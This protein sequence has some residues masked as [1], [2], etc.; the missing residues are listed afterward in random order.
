[1][2]RTLFTTFFV[3]LALTSLSA[4]QA[5]LYIGSDWCEADKGLEAI[6]QKA[7]FAKKAKIPLATVDAPEVI[8]E[9]VKAQWKAQEAIHWELENI[10]AFAYF[11]EAGRCVFLRE[12][13][14]PLTGDAAEKLLLDL[15]QAGKQRAEK[16]AALTATNSAESI[17]E[18]LSL[19]VPELGVRRSKEARGAKSLWETLKQS[20]PEDKSGW[21][22]ALTFDPAEKD[23]YVINEAIAKG[24]PDV[25]QKHLAQLEAKP[26]T[27][28]STNQKQ[29]LKLLR[30]L[31]LKEKDKPLSNTQVAILKEVI[32]MD[33]TTHY[34]IAAQGELCRKGLGPVAIPYGWFPKDAQ[35]GTHT[36]NITVGTQKTLRAAG[37]YEL[38]LK[39]TKGRGTMRFEGLTIG[40]K[41][42]GQTQTLIVGNTLAIPFTISAAD[43]KRPLKL[44]VS[45]EQPS[46]EYGK[47]SLRALLPER[48]ATPQMKVDAKATPWKAKKG[49]SAVAQWARQM[50]PT[51]TFRAIAAQ[52]NGAQFLTDFFADTQWMEDFFASGKPMTRWEDALKALDAIAYYAP[53]KSQAE[54]KWATAAALNATEDPTEIVRLYQVM[55]KSRANKQFVQGADDLRVDQ[56]R[57][58]LLP[59]H[60]PAESAEWMVKH[61]SMPPRRYTWACWYAPYRLHN[62]FGD[63]I[64][65]S[66]YYSAWEHAYIRHENARKIG[67]V[68]GSLSY[69]GSAATKAHGIPSVPAGQPSHCA[70][71]NWSNTENRWIFG[72]YVNPYSGTHFSVWNAGSDFAYQDLQADSFAN[73]EMRH[74]MRLLWQVESLRQRINPNPTYAP[75]RC[76][77]YVWHGR[78]LPTDLSTLE[79]L[80]SW[81]AVETFDINQAQRTDNLFLRWQ[82]TLSVTKETPINFSV[83]S[84]DGA[85]L[86]LDG[87][88]IAGK[89]GTHGV[90]GSSK[91]RTLAP[92]KYPFEVRY[93]NLNGGRSLNVQIEARYPY[94]KRWALAYQQAAQLC[95]T[96]LFVWQ[97]YAAW[98]NSC[99]AVPAEAWREYG[100]C[101]ANA[102]RNHVAPAWQL[103]QKYALPQIKALAD[104]ATMAEAMIAWH[105]TIRQGSHVTSEFF[106]YSK[107]LKEHAK[108]LENQPGALFKCFEAALPRQYG[109]ANAFGPLVKWGG[110]QF[111]S[112]P[113]SSARYVVALNT[114]LSGDA[115]QDNA[116]SKYLREAIREA[117]MI[118]NAEAFHA[119]SDLQ[120][121]LAPQEFATLSFENISHPL[122]SDK[123]ILRT[124][125]TSQWDRIEYYRHII[126]NTAPSDK[127]FHTAGE[128]T[129]WAEVI[130]PGMA[131][132]STIYIAN[133]PGNNWRLVP[134]I[135]SVSEDGKEWLDVAQADKVQ[136]TYTFDIPPTKAKYIRI[137]AHPKGEN[138]KTFLHLRKFCVFGKKLY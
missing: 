89:D 34:G 133:T 49:E 104:E 14:P 72:Y 23:C 30:Y 22:F 53:P 117:S 50:I 116:L 138:P 105:G 134:F 78:Q 137:T 48:V 40:K 3:I 84:D 12:M 136:A 81:Q 99:E 127:N 41:R 28:L 93:F 109:T 108:L 31:S 131:E 54:K 130:L 16:I 35:P 86:W 36:W 25:A 74:S 62:F 82:G 51:T 44:N 71:T 95:P 92:G 85:G 126:D 65:G 125:S 10:P 11:D 96:N 70:Y 97:A 61:H 110:E 122:L 64:H 135:L 106:N 26:Q 56:M 29:G 73:P 75:M 45:F 52:P 13:L 91:C 5:V 114:L 111:L 9:E 132:V 90:E 115:E 76:D 112:Q 66:D 18:A 55:M 39:R 87:E 57:Y 103:L 6:W 88:K 118:E 121:K 21:D 69:Y 4:Q 113:D 119:L 43:I 15:I 47:L 120:D 67:G 124:S 1:M 19:I 128:A 101:V 102:L 94:D 32:A 98:L 33:P 83:M 17:G 77:A 123:G 68:C 7:S 59:N 46:E 79:K 63:S 2:L 107:M 60:S 80:G 20:D 129:P 100:D 38:T 37:R 27:H 24:Q 8:T 58:T 42:F